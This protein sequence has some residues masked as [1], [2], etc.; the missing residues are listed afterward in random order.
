MKAIGYPEYGPPNLLNLKEVQDPTPK[1][2]EMLLEIHAASANPAGWHLPRGEPYF[3]RLQLG[4]SKPK[5]R[6]LGCD[7]A[8]Q[9]EAV[10]E[11]V[12]MLQPGDEVFGS[13]F[14]DRFGA[15]AACVYPEEAER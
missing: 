14:V 8:G 1:E 5:D 6:I 12:T 3:A 15:F 7:V 13:P 2:D 9:V 10:G 11:N 4:L